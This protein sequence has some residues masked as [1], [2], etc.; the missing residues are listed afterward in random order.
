[1]RHLFRKYH[2]ISTVVGVLILGLV[3][4]SAYAQAETQEETQEAMA[5]EAFA[6]PAAR[7]TGQLAKKNSFSENSVIST[8]DYLEI[9]LGLLFIVCLIYAGAWM[10]KRLNGGVL[11]SANKMR[12]VSG[13]SLGAREKLLLVDVAGTQLLLGV[14]PGRVSSLHVFESPV[15]DAQMGSAADSDFAKKLK[16]LIDS[17]SGRDSTAASQVETPLCEVPAARGGVK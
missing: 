12:I 6:K 13:L 10:V 9:T 4:L 5:E 7:A 2:R 16:G 3:C 11:Q 15:V 8:S 1:M 17:R 14:A